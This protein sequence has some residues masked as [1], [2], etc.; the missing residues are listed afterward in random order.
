MPKLKFVLKKY[1][2]SMCYS[3]EFF[4]LILCKETSW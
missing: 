1:Y 3:E 4:D 2:I